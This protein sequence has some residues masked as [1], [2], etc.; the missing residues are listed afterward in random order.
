[1]DI[2]QQINTALAGR[3]TQRDFVDSLA[4]RWN[5]L[6]ASFN[7]LVVLITELART[8]SAAQAKDSTRAAVFDGIRDYF[9]TDGD[10]QS[11]TAALS[12][13]LAE[14]ADRIGVLHQRVC[15][16][17]V[18]IGVIG[19]TGAGKSTLLRKLSGLGED[20]IPSN[21]FASST[22]T[23][24]RIFHDSGSAEGRAVLSLHTW[25]TFRDEVLQPLHERAGLTAPPPGT[26]DEFRRFPYPESIP[27][28]QAGSERFTRRLRVARDS[29]PSYESMLRGG[30]EQIT[31]DRLRP[32]VAYP[33]DE[34]SYQRPY[35]AVRSVD[36]FC[37]FPEVGAVRLGLVDLP[38]SGEAGL[39]VHKRFLADLRN[40]ADLLFI[41]RRPVKTPATDQDWDAAQLADDAAAG[42][43]RH[44]FAHLVINRDID[45]SEEY[46]DQALGRAENDGANLGI[47]VR[48]C[49]IHRAEP[50]RV[51]E[52]I[53]VPI[54]DHLATRLAVMD[55]DA[56]AFVLTGLSGV[57]AEV[58]TLCRDL[59]RQFGA[60]EGKLPDK[61]K[62]S[63]ERIRKLR[64]QIGWDLDRVRNEYDR[65]YESGEP[66]A[67]LRQQIEKA[68]REVKQWLAS[69]LGTGSRD[70]WI[71][72]FQKAMAV[73][74]MGDELDR[75][76]NGTREKVVE[77]F[78]EIDASLELAIDRLHG[79]V[80]DALRRTLT[81]KLVP[82][83]PD[84]NEVLREF[85]AIARRHRAVKLAVATERLLALRVDYGNIFLRVG[86]PVVRRIRWYPD[87]QPL[88]AQQG[89][90]VAG[91][92]IPGTADRAAGA[93]GAAV[94]HVIGG[95]VGQAVGEAMGETLSSAV[96]RRASQAEQG[97][98]NWL[99]DHVSGSAARRPVR[100][101]SAP[102]GSAR[103]GS[104]PPGSA[105]AQTP[106]PN[107][108]AEQ[109]PDAAGRYN[110][111]TATVEDVIGELTREFQ[112]EARRALRVLAAAV[113]LYK[114][115]A[116][117]APDIDVEFE[118]VS[119]LAQQEI[120]PQ[121][122]SEASSKI[123]AEM[124]ALREHT[125][126]TEAAADQLALLVNQAATLGSAVPPAASRPSG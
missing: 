38:G 96:R 112:A 43:R 121:E 1:M 31:L 56:V 105:S 93:A 40:S 73:S 97:S 70:N 92:V 106:G 102:P 100:A 113:D 24:S 46:F 23:P 125:G 74:G 118:R 58:R 60:W 37:Q 107:P 32:F 84:N 7:A 77:M 30:T 59:D 19:M 68:G 71:N 33:A 115:S 35:H 54:L 3:A 103:P 85:G 91:Q 5:G 119:R 45:L 62:L 109:Y 20:H 101:A 53:L 69:G 48:V 104:A 16:E 18:N 75:Q 72:E 123:T 90:A 126:V 117:T 95:P 12:A 26:I 63:R 25:P 116:T 39:D 8:A 78:A 13:K 42:V 4:D 17:T 82:A 21:K 98:G 94:G 99:S 110:Q 50:P 86:R 9:G 79:E 111:L 67:E 28:H 6:T 27:E 76:Y 122:F 14:G 34:S 80:A 52:A 55:R 22:A 49:D 11:R 36:I 44:D 89:A 51:I 2:Q 81:G 61:D 124:A 47:D 114:D 64:Y 41:V 65:L 88:T 66:I 29:L 10:W 108:S 83:G 120:W 87:G 15:R 57:A